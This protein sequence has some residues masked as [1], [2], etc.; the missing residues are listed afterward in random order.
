MLETQF[1]LLFLFLFFFCCISQCL[2]PW[3]NVE[4][5]IVLDNLKQTLI[6]KEYFE[7]CG[8]WD[9]MTSM[10]QRKQILELLEVYRSLTALWDL[11]SPDYTN[12]QLKSEQYN[13]LYEKYRETHP[14]ATRKDLGRRLNSL[15]TNYRREYN[16][17]KN[18]EI[19]PE[20]PYKPTLFY[21]DALS[22]LSSVQSET[23]CCTQSSNSLNV[24]IEMC[25]FLFCFFL[26]ENFC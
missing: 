23:K 8:C 9:E 21:Y 3:L 4:G 10:P 16:R 17:V 20:G 6:W 14:N 1:C 19:T 12:R 18:G 2:T 5:G 11:R 25:F 7:K 22:F 13:I 24:S 26:I 15:R